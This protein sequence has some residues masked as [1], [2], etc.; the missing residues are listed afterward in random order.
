MQL[1]TADTANK[2]KTYDLVSISIFTTI[3]AICSWI[4]I[5]TAVPFTLQTLGVFLSVAILGGKKGTL[6]VL[7]YILIGAAGV[8]VFSGFS[9][10][11][12]YLLGSTGGYIFGFLFTALIMWAMERLFGKKPVVLA[13]SMILGL[14]SCYAIGTAWYLLIYLRNSGTIG[15]TTVLGWCVFPFIIPDL[16]KIAVALLISERLKKAV[17]L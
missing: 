6:S 11:F 8:P 9:G 4:S 13:I 17:R 16:C 1:H 2:L 5:P 3:I 14:L 7:L 15:L 10:G 12:G